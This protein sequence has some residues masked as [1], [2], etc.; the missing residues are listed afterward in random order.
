MTALQSR[1]HGAA[2]LVVGMR[3]IA[4]SVQQQPSGCGDGGDD[5][6]VSPGAE[7]L[8]VAGQPAGQP[9]R[10]GGADGARQFRFDVMA[11]QARVAAGV[12]LHGV[13]HQHGALAI[14]VDT[15]ALVDQVGGDH[16]HA[17]GLG[18]QSADG[19]VAVPPRPIL[20]A[21]AVE[22]PVHR[23]HRPVG[24]VDERRPD[25]AHPRVVQRCF[26]DVDARREIPVGGRPLTGVHH[27]GHRFELG[28][29]V[30]DRRPG[31]PRLVPGLLGVAKGVAR[32]GE[33]HPNAFLRRVFGRHPGI[34]AGDHRGGV[35]GGGMRREPVA[36]KA[37]AN[38]SNRVSS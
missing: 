34:H 33:G 31:G 16:R 36:S 29:G 7:P 12:K 8:R 17:G 35:R 18:Y 15:A 4:L 32:G 27:H 5:V 14:D 6:H 13:G 30:G 2:H 10:V 23:C 21:P 37:A 38:D 28:D 9:H 19:G 22:H 11:G 1:P 24:G 3:G 25:I 20:G 26:D